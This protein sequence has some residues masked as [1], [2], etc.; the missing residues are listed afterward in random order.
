MK[1]STGDDIYG[2]DWENAQ[3]D[4]Q[5]EI[6]KESKKDIEEKE[7]KKKEEIDSLCP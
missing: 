4:L 3:M 1:T 7:K 6:E 5:N 2:I